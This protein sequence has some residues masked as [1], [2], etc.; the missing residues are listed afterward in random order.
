[1]II[2]E[3]RLGPNIS[4]YFLMTAAISIQT[5]NADFKNSPSQ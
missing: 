4:T 1:M 3:S 2:G 5:T